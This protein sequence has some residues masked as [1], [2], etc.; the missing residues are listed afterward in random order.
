MPKFADA[1]I[2]VT[3]ANGQ[4]GRAVI[5]HLREGGARRIVGLTR[6]PAKAAAH[7]G[8]G[9]ELRRADFHDPASL[10]AA[11]AGVDR[12]LIVSTDTLAG[13]DES[14]G[15]AIDAA[16]KAGVSTI[17]YTSIVSPYPDTRP[18]A[19]I[20]ATHF[21]TEVRI[22]ASGVDFALLRNNLYADFLIPTAQNAIASGS[23]YHAAGNGRRAYVTRED[24]AR[25]A[26]GA[27]LTSEGKRIYEVSGPAALSPDDLAAILADLSGKPVTA[28]NIPGE[29][30][31]G[32]LTQAGI[33]PEFA[34][35]LANFDAD[36]AKGLLAI[37]SNDIETLSGH[38]PTSVATFLAAHKAAI[39]G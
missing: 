29:A 26:A 30:L 36:A 1:T 12:L 28:V 6:D 15:A 35:I 25:A 16:V 27:L 14:Q 33:P 4:L 22:A 10:P 8:D 39:L 17:A 23:L 34:S 37:V 13:R 20:P 19:L 3:G 5:R 9:V 11:F 7:A 21:W 32:G 24:C 38:A 2:A 18:A 31:V